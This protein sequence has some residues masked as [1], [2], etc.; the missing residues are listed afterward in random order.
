MQPCHPATNRPNPPAAR[1]AAEALLDAV[2]A[3]MRTIR[4][5]MRAASSADLSVVQFRSL[6]LSS[7]APG[8]AS[9]SEIADHIGL[10]LPSASKLVDN[11]VRRGYLSRRPD[12]SDRR[13]SR[14]SATPKG[15]RLVQRARAATLDH[16]ATRLSLTPPAR[17]TR[18]ASVAEH[19][20]PL[21]AAPTPKARSGTPRQS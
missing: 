21:F 7:F 18:I 13:T 14:C 11:L 9:V 12:P 20:T 4:Q 8:G 2:P 19:L 10:T 3:V 17:L 6:A 5:Q 1:R 15:R 16:L